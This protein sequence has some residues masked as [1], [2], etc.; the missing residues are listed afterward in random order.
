MNLA[1]STT[2][3]FKERLYVGSLPGRYNSQYMDLSREPEGQGGARGRSY[4][5]FGWIHT[6]TLHFPTLRNL[7]Q[8]LVF[9]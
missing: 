3:C 5:V 6:T 9:K 2:L 1:Q 4:F 8:V 7:D